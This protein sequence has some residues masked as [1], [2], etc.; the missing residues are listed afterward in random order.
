M[1]C[2]IGVAELGDADEIAVGGAE[3]D[4]FFAA[5]AAACV[6][7]FDLVLAPAAAVELAVGEDDADGHA[8]HCDAEDAEGE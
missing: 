7:P 1:V 2:G 6:D 4:L 8:N 5:R 3:I